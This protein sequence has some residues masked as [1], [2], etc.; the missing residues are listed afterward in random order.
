MRVPRLPVRSV[1]AAAALALAPCAL[2][3]DGSPSLS[4]PQAPAPS[5]EQQ[6]VDVYNDGIAL[7]DKAAAYEKEAAAEPDAKKKAS[8]E[9]KAK[10]KH[11]SS[12]KKF[13]KATDKDPRLVEAWGS[14]GYAYRKT[15]D[16]K[17]SLDAYGKA[18]ELKPTY[19]PAIEYRAEAYLGLGRLD[20]VKAAYMTLFN[21]DRPRA[22]ELSA[23][24]DR[25]L[26]QRRT[27]PA[28][29][30]PAAVEE[31][32]KWAADRKRLAAQTSWAGPPGEP[33]W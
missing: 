22:N 15:G 16:F 6:A 5:L 3:A 14:L 19:T 10:D 26:E 12:I 33:R 4:R 20:D 7:R 8:L 21:V 13:V 18:L 11:L 1:L 17:S 32:G 27:D 23:A 9:A 30:E 29:L 28:G 31:F 25:W 2:L 24:I